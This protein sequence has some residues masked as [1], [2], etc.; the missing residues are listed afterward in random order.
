[1]AL[2]RKQWFDVK[3]PTFTGKIGCG[4]RLYCSKRSTPDKYRTPEACARRAART[5][6][7]RA[8]SRVTVLGV[9]AGKEYEGKRIRIWAKDRP[10]FKV[11]LVSAR[12][13]ST[14]AAE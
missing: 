12:D 14:A 6:Y 1:M 3:H 5:A 2:D 4:I 13:A 9:G 10:S 7:R 11:W 8:H